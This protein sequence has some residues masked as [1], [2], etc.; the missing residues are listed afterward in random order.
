MLNKS[1]TWLLVIDRAQMPWSCVVQR[2][3]V[4]LRADSK[5]VRVLEIETK[6]NVAARV[7]CTVR[8]YRTAYSFTGFV[9][10]EAGVGF[11]CLRAAALPGRGCQAG[12]ISV[13]TVNTRDP[14]AHLHV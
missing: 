14:L 6:L 10:C 2:P 4:A 7:L 11:R 3:R 13:R 1:F 5:R 9:P 8:C 12:A